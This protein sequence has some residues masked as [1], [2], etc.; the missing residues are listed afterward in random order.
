MVPVLASLIP[1]LVNKGLELF[2]KKF[3]SDG[4]KAE[5]AREFEKYLQEQIQVAWNEEQRQLTERHKNDMQS[6]SW[7]SKNI[8]PLVLVYLMG[9]FTLA[10]FNDVPQQVL[11]MLQDLLMT[12]FMFYFGARTIEKVGKMMTAGEKGGVIKWSK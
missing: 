1:T 8:R 10:F 4:E 2:D 6:D 5:K 3:E 11:Q 9:L 7:L 12:S